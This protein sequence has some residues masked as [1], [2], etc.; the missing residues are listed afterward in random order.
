LP[1]SVEASSAVRRL[2][3]SMEDGDCWAPPPLSLGRA[4]PA[5]DA[6]VA[7]GVALMAVGVRVP[8]GET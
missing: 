3:G 2:H 6:A 4:V 7:I 8:C 1:I 5:D